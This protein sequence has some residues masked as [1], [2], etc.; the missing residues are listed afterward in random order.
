MFDLEREFSPERTTVTQAVKQ[1]VEQRRRDVF[2]SH[3]L[4]T[5]SLA[6]YMTGN[7]LEAEEILLN[8]F[9][10][11][12]RK[13][14]RPDAR[15][16]DSALICEFRERFCLE[17]ELPAATPPGECG[18]RVRNVRRPELEAALLDLPANERLLYLLRDVE[19]YSPDVIAGL[20]NVSKPELQRQLF[21]ARLRL[22]QRLAVASRPASEAA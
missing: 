22:C 8:T 18:A 15:G 19:G 3:R 21:S 6:F 1:S 14:E 20:L 17:P 12:F 2:E 4:R 7:E 10:R 16:I 11:A 13:S 9:V 5:F